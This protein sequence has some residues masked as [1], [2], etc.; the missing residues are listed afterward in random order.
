MTVVLSGCEKKD[1][2]PA[3]HGA[4]PSKPARAALP[5]APKELAGFVV[6]ATVVKK[7]ANE[8]P[9]VE[10]KGKQVPNWVATLSRGEMLTLLNE[11][12]DYQRVKTSS[13][14]EGWVKKT[15]I[16]AA[17]D[18]QVATVL[19]EVE[20]FDRPDLLTLNSKKTVRAGTLLFVQK[21]KG[22]FSEVNVNGWTSAWVLTSKL[23]HDSNE[24]SVSKMLAR[25]RELKAANNASGA[26]ELLKLAR[27]TSGATK[28]IGVFEN[29]L[30]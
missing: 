10:E 22:Q 6:V 18:V 15:A 5:E 27:S 8:A 11:E 7:A 30:Q 24:I 2:P 1:G 21:S 25:A 4:A 28:L 23:S 20:A 26:E 3:A 12:G 29:E 17:S 13:D 16:L 9:K 14:V 19:G